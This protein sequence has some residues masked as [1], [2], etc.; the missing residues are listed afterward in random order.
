MGAKAKEIGRYKMW[1]YGFY[2]TRNGVGIMVEQ[3]LIE[4][5]V[6]VR[7]KSDH[8]MSIKLVVG[9]EIINTVCVYAPKKKGLE[10]EVKRLFWEELNE[11]I[12][13]MPRPKRLFIGDDFNG[14]I[15]GER[16]GYEAIHEGFGFGERNNGE[17]FILDFAVACDLSLINSHF[18][19]KEEHLVT[20]K[21]G[22]TRS[23]IDLFL[24][25]VYNRRDCKDYKVIPSECLMK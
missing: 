19:K 8:I 10:D 24:L 5:V 21:S 2:R 6:E 1:Y 11:V 4:Q 25:R 12:Q 15:E 7:H 18:K 13:S 17:V 16:Y 22:N 14:H 3:R 9:L 20:F 23:Q